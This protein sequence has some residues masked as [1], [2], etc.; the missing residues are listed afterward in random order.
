[1]I[2]GDWGRLH[3]LVMPNKHLL[4]EMFIVWRIALLYL[5]LLVLFLGFPK[6]KFILS[7]GFSEKK[8]TAETPCIHY[9][10]QYM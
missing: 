7:K 3:Y 4:N 10:M 2:G 8:I 6:V 5:L 1:M 9:N